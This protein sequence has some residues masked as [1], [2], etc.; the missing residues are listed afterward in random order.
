[1]FWNREVSIE[2]IKPFAPQNLRIPTFRTTPQK[3]WHSFQKP[4]AGS[5]HFKQLSSPVELFCY[6]QNKPLSKSAEL[7]ETSDTN[8]NLST[9]LNLTFLF[10]SLGL[11]HDIFFSLD[12]IKMA[13]STLLGMLWK[14]FP[15]AFFIIN[16]FQKACKYNFQPHSTNLQN[17]TSS[18]CLSFEDFSVSCI[19]FIR[20][21]CKLAWGHRATEDVL[22]NTGVLLQISGNTNKYLHCLC[23]RCLPFKVM[24]PTLYKIYNL[25]CQFSFVVL[26]YSRMNTNR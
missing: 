22:R 9:K 4:N 7:I 12:I 1:M 19:V 26:L 15:R 17:L 6:I 23:S 13:I 11:Q 8:P 3:G 2:T 21:F 5:W 25:Y 16:I 24:S 20:L 10:C 14:I 18:L